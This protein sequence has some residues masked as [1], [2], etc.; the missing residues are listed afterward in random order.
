MGAAQTI[1]MPTEM[2]P[3]AIQALLDAKEWDEMDLA[4]RLGV[5]TRSV[6]NWLNGENR[7]QR[8]HRRRMRAWLLEAGEEAVP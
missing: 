2:T 3:D 8:S 6:Q 4:Y 1:A 5:T 7:P